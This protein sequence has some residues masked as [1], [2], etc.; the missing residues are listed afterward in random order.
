ME[1]LSVVWILIVNRSWHPNLQTQLSASF[2]YLEINGTVV[3][4]NIV[5]RLDKWHVCFF[6]GSKQETKSCI[7]Y[8]TP[9][10]MHKH[11]VEAALT[12]CPKAHSFSA[13][14]LVQVESR[15]LCETWIQIIWKSPIFMVFRSFVQLLMEGAFCREHRNRAIQ[16]NITSL[17]E[18]QCMVSILKE[19]KQI[20]S[21]KDRKKLYQASCAWWISTIR[22]NKSLHKC[23]AQITNMLQDLNETLRLMK[24]DVCM[25]TKPRQNSCISSYSQAPEICNS[26]KVIGDCRCF[27]KRVLKS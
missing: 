3:K 6:Y 7:L 13:V 8:L 25:R 20:V 4:I 12:R 26:E 18:F 5:S 9:D 10:V 2:C 22:A 15:S 1:I 24:C 19:T 14:A 21:W 23:W 11:A 27:G 17:F 16:T